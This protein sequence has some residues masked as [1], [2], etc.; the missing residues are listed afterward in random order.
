LNAHD[1]PRRSPN[2]PSGA[3]RRTITSE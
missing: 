2:E 3:S 1:A